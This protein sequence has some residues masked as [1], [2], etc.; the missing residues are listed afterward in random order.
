MYRDYKLNRS[1]MK[2]LGMLVFVLG[3]IMTTL[4]G[5]DIVTRKKVAEIGPIAITK[6]NTTPIYWSPATG[7]TLAVAGVVLLFIGGKRNSK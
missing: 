6:E 1:I 2:K 3:I 7:A 5:F 4:T